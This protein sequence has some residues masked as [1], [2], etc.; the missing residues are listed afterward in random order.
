MGKKIISSVIIIIINIAFILLLTPCFTSKHSNIY[1]LF[2]TY[3]GDKMII[4][5]IIST[6]FGALIGGLAYPMLKNY[7][8]ERR[9]S[10]LEQHLDSVVKSVS[11]SK[12]QQ[13]RQVNTERQQ[14]ALSAV[15][16]A[17]SSGANPTDAIKQVAL[18]YPDVAQQ[19]LKGGFKL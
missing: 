9:I 3:F 14:E 10:A 2:I 19:L 5:T 8:I 15:V 4:E 6:G 18:S 16:A 12:G 11:G 13:Q 7:A 1:M 17:I